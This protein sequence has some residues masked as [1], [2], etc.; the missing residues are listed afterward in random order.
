MAQHHQRFHFSTFSQ[1][2]SREATDQIRWACVGDNVQNCILLLR[3]I[4]ILLYAIRVVVCYTCI[5]NVK[6]SIYSKPLQ[7]DHI[8]SDLSAEELVKKK[9]LGNR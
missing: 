9:Q 1:A 8:E 5:T 2:A 4:I 3:Y 6:Y 7:V